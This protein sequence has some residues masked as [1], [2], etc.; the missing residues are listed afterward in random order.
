[1]IEF[2]A[3]GTP[4]VVSRAIEEFAA[5][6]RTVSAIV[7]P[8]ESDRTTLTMSVTAVTGEG[9]AIEHTNL[10]TIRLTDLGNEHT[11]VTV[12]AET[13]DQA[14]EK[15]RAAFFGRFVREIQ[16]RFAAES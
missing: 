3:S 10:G 14:E 6:Q 12:A 16:S 7:V 2:V 4:R 13:T 8:W 15:K 1:M 9:W 5:G 11:Q